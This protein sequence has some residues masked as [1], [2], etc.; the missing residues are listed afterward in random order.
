MTTRGKLGRWI[1]LLAPGVVDKLALKALN[2]H[3]RPQ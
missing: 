1:K 3:A 2:Q